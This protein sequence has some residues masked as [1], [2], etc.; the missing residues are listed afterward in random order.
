MKFEVTDEAVINFF[1]QIPI[2][3]LI[4]RLTSNGYEV[5]SAED[6]PKYINIEKSMGTE[7]FYNMLIDAIEKGEM[8]LE[9]LVGKVAL[10]KLMPKS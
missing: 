2:Q 3:F 8:S 4:D 7:P 9:L 1:D 5:V 6:L 10:K